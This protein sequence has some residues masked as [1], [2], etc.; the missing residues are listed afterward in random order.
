MGQ[1]RG[2]NSLGPI[3]LLSVAMHL[4][5]VKVVLTQTEIVFQFEEAKWKPHHV[6]NGWF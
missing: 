2:E 6:Y 3:G 5:R 1:G 4:N